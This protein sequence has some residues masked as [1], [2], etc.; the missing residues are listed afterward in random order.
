MD[1]FPWK[2]ELGANTFSGDKIFKEE[3]ELG[4]ISA[5]R[6]TLVNPDF[7]ITID[8]NGARKSGLVR[9]N[10]DK[11]IILI[12][13]SFAQGW[14][15]NDEETFSSKLEKKYSNLKVYNYGQGGYGTIQS[16][17]LLKK[18]IQKI[19]KPKLV[20]YVFIDHHEFRNAARMSWMR[21]LASLSESGNVKLPY[22]TIGEEDE[23]IIKPPISNLNFPLKDKSSIITIL[24]KAISKNM[25]KEHFPNDRTR[26]KQQEMITKKAIMEIKNVSNSFNTKFLITILD[27]A[28]QNILNNYENFFKENKI[29]FAD[30]HISLTNEMVIVGDYHPSSKAH[31]H[32]SE[33]LYKHISK[34]NLLN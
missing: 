22:G 8:E 20:I 7:K 4:W 2:Y 16:L 25:S 14:G 26:K 11:S 24:E 27:A 34:E 9:K 12:G 32:Y 13:G 5:E 6:V 23:L 29:N 30:C 21:T 10:F 15:V 33:C 1:I 3:S 17:L 19:E 18:K 31:S 28:N